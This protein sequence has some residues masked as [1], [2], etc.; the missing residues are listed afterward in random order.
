MNAISTVP[1]DE[2]LGKHTSDV[3]PDKSG[4]LQVL[5][6]LPGL[7]EMRRPRYEKRVD[8]LE[9]RSSVGFLADAGRKYSVELELRNGV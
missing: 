4:K 9:Q 5:L 8:D 3:S 6:Q 2:Q 7:Q 1:A